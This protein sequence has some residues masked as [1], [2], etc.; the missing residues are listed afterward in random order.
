MPGEEVYN[1]SPGT[2]RIRK[3][4]YKLEASL[5]LHSKFTTERRERK[6]QTDRR[7][8]GPHTTGCSKP[9]Y[10]GRYHINSVLIKFTPM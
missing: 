3:E 9:P 6:G 5:K 10:Y 1:C 4:D 7:R 2:G 8:A